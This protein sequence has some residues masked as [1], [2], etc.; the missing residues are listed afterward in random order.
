MR[1]RGESE[2]RFS[3]L[4]DENDNSHAAKLQLKL[5]VFLSRSY[6]EPDGREATILVVDSLDADVAD[7]EVPP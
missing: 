6:S 1:R 2:N 4:S 3:Q 7:G 5:R